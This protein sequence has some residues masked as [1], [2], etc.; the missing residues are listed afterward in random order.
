MSDSRSLGFDVGGDALDEHARLATVPQ[1]A[2]RSVAA[3]EHCDRVVLGLLPTFFD[4]R[5]NLARDMLDE[6]RVVG[7]H[8]VFTASSATR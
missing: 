5:T 4:A 3:S 1:D 2:R 7:D 6:L 8:H